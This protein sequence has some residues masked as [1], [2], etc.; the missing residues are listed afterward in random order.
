[1]EVVAVVASVVTLAELACNIFKAAEK[2]NRYIHSKDSLCD[3]S[4]NIAPLIVDWGRLK[5]LEG[6]IAENSS[7]LD[8]SERGIVYSTLQGVEA[9][10]SQAFR[11]CVEHSTGRKISVTHFKWVLR[12][13]DTW[14]SI[15]S[16]LRD[17]EA[18]LS[19]IINILKWSVVLHVLLLPY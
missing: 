3:I 14:K 17:E 11:F 9:T 15:S 16:R 10:I 18:K 19:S 2:L 12:D 1:M 6:L 7:L 5:V 4:K 13:S 8:H